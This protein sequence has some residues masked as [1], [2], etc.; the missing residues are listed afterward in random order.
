MYAQMFISAV[1]FTETASL[2]QRD[3]TKFKCCVTWRAIF[4]FKLY[5]LII[6]YYLVLQ[7]T[8]TTFGKLVVI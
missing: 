2:S 5:L 7:I 8:V 4:I 1:V 3:L 6:L